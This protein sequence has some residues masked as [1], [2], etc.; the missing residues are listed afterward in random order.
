MQIRKNVLKSQKGIKMLDNLREKIINYVYIVSKQPVLYRDLLRANRLF[1][2]G[3]YVDPGIL[4]FRKNL[5][6]EYIAYGVICTA[7]LLPLLIITHTLFTKLD[8]HISLVGTVVVTSA[9]F[10]GFNIFHIWTRKAIT[11]KLIKKA[12][13]LHFPYFPYEKYSEKVEIIFQ[14]ALKKEVLRKDLEQYVLG[15]LVKD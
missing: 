6:K 2:E 7:I 11:K 1:N 13:E 12:W 15:R 5:T 10:I 9:V 8:F 14:E 4:N 3:M